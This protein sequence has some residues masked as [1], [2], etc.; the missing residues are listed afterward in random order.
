MET[1]F[2]VNLLVL[3]GAST[4][5]IFSSYSLLLFLSFFSPL[6]FPFF[7]PFLS[8]FSFSFFFNKAPQTPY[9]SLMYG[10][11]KVL[12]ACPKTTPYIPDWVSWMMHPSARNGIW[13]INFVQTW[14]FRKSQRLHWPQKQLLGQVPNGGCKFGLCM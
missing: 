3:S 9:I 5:R 11:P 12:H 2:V 14:I 7:V 1:T 10:L 13:K 8:L 4:R 6:L